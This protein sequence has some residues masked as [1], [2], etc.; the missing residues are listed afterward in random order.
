MKPL[1][2]A[3]ILSV[4]VFFTG[5][6]SGDSASY[7]LRLSQNRP[8]G[9]AFGKSGCMYMVTAPPTGS[10]TLS[11]VS[12][13]GDIVQMAVLDGT[14]IGPGITLDKKG[15]VLVTVGDKLLS[16]DRK[17]V[18]TTV[19][20]G[21]SRAFD[22]KLDGRG[23]IYVADDGKGVVYRIRPQKQREIFYQSDSIGSFRL[24]S[25]CL[26]ESSEH[27][28]VRDGRKLLRFRLG[29]GDQR[30]KPEVVLDGIDVFYMCAGR[31]NMIYAST[32]NNVIGLGGH[33]RT[34]TL[35]VNNLNAP[36]GLALGG[37][38]FDR[39]SLYV[40]EAGGIVRVPIGK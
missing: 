24:T 22:V 28:T 21:F 31:Q 5:G 27:L 18:L 33:R 36:V 19:Q 4:T 37:A 2:A 26:D 1:P 20:E 15:N 12:P 17:G 11:R 30:A 38:G 3:L 40:A 14:F 35:S 25:I 13:R 23:N 34:Q 16:V 7:F 9:V 8:Y 29:S 6:F 39:N 10:G 32:T